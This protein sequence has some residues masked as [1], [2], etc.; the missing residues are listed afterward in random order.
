[1]PEWLDTRHEK[2]AIVRHENF[3]PLRYRPTFN[4]NTVALNLHRIPDL[5]EQF[6]YFNDDM[7][8]TAPVQ[9]RDFFRNGFPADMAVQDMIPSVEFSEYWRM[10]FQNITLL[11]QRY[12]KKAYQK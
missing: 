11:N 7:F 1:M 8:L 6:V 12:T 4:P 2:L 10:Y 5:S 3:L 9:P